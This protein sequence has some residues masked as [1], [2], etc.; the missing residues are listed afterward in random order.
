M[1]AMLLLA[2]SV[3]GGDPVADARSPTEPPH[4]AVR[5]GRVSAELH[6]VPRDAALQALAKA[7]GAEVWGAVRDPVP[8]SHRFADVPIARALDRL[9]GPQNFLLRYGADGRVASIELIGVAQPPAPAPERGKPAA[10]ARFDQLLARHPPVPVTGALRTA[11]RQ[12]TTPLPQLVALAILQP[13]AQVRTDAARTVLRAVE[14]DAT[15]RAAMLERLRGADTAAIVRLARQ[16]GRTRAEE[17]LGLVSRE[18]RTP[19]LRVRAA[20]ALAELERP[21]T[22]AQR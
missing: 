4:F 2:A 13:D 8:V 3:V 7:L 15:L 12:D 17:L 1:L 18:A 11:V 9:L 16:R 21:A 19:L 14:D 10:E 22:T 20:Q 6:D 5:S